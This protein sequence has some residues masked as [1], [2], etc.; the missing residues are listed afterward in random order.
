MKAH[1][2][3]P[4][5]HAASCFD[6]PLPDCVIPTDT[7]AEQTNVIEYDNPAEGYA[8][9]RKKRNGPKKQKSPRSNRGR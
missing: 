4:C 8:K 7:P 1:K 5:K 3:I 6:C 9:V 2:N